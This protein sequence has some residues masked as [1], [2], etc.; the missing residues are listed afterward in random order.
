MRK[1]VLLATLLVIAITSGVVPGAE[2]QKRDGFWWRDMPHDWKVFYVRGY[3][4]AF[5]DAN[6][7][8][9]TLGLPKPQQKIVR[10]ILDLYNIQIGQYVDGVDN[11]YSDYRN[12]KID[13]AFAIIFSRDEIRGKSEAEQQ[14]T[15]RKLRGIYADAK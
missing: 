13:F 5:S 1:R 2:K 8:I 10:N 12:E 15:L 7:L 11:F 4:D 9:E 3:V 6:V 14:E